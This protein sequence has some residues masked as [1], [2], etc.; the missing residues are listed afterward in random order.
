MTNPDGIVQYTM[1]G[2][3]ITHADIAYARV[4]MSE[5]NPFNRFKFRR[6]YGEYKPVP[7]RKRFGLSK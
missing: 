5:L 3:T 4:P 1:S 7:F 2:S 6:V